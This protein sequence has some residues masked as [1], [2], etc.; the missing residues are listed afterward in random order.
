VPLVQL[1]RGDALKAWLSWDRRPRRVVGVSVMLG[2]FD[3]A[4]KDAAGRTLL[5]L[6]LVGV[7]GRPV[8]DRMPLNV[9]SPGLQ[10]ATSKANSPAGIG[11]NHPAPV[12]WL[13]PAEPIVPGMSYITCPGNSVPPPP[14]INRVSLVEL[15]YDDYL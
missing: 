5:S 13:D 1:L 2:N 10:L 6:V 15:Y 4:D 12:W 7:S 9:L 14:V 3:V 8:V 11:Y